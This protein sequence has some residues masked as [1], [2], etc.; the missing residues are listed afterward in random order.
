MSD[1]ELAAMQARI[2]L[3]A[4]RI[5]QAEGYAALS[6]RQ[7]A[8]GLGLTAG[9]L[10]R[11]FSTKQHVLLAS[12]GAA[13]DELTEALRRIEAGEPKPLRALERMMVADGD[14]A[15]AAT[16][17]FR[18]VLL[19]P[20]VGEIE[21]PDT[22]ALD[23]YRV[24]QGTVRQAQEAALLRPIPN[25]DI[26]CI[27]VGCVHGLVVMAITIREIDVSDIE[28]LVATAARATL[29]GLAPSDVEIEP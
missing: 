21:I 2:V 24:L 13:L 20:D 14:F 26:A 12:C 8:A 16:D 18:V 6:M 15:L 3:E 11:Y 23:G 25:H 22:K 1:D 17:R 5:V 27:L 4:G 29:R 28:P 9:A 10:H 19:D 7:L